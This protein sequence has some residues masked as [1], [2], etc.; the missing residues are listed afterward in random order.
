MAELAE[1]IAAELE[2]IDGVLA[3]VPSAGSLPEPHTRS[4]EG[5]PR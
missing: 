3:L 1:R 5:I 2:N 4:R